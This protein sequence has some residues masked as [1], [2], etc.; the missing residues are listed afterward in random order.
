MKEK[1]LYLYVICKNAKIKPSNYP[2]KSLNVLRLK[3]GYLEVKVYEIDK[4]ILT[5]QFQ[6]SIVGVKDYLKNWS[7]NYFEFYLLNSKEK[8]RYLK[9]LLVANLEETK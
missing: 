6:E 9:P 4:N 7:Y 1:E 2:N 8:Q 5:Q 3:G